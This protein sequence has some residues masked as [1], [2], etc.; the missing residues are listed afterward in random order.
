MA[1]SYAASEIQTTGQSAPSGLFGRSEAIWARSRLNDEGDVAVDLDRRSI[2]SGRNP[3]QRMASLLIAI[4]RNNSYEGR[5]P[6]AI[7][8]SLTSG[9]VAQLLGIEVRALVDL[10]VALEHQNL[11]AAVPA[12]GLR[13]TNL[14]GL[15]RLADA[16]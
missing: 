3:L 4:S 7:P 16:H 13:L 10:L 1:M 12:A 6:H 8:D 14:A 15:E 5:D 11:I 2:A 9:F